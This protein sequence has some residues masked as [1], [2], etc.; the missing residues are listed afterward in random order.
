MAG[1]VLRSIRWTLLGLLLAPIA[2]LLAILPAMSPDRSGI[3]PGAF[4]SG[5]GAPV[6]SVI[7]R[8]A[9]GS[10]RPNIVVILADDLG[11]GDL[12]V[13]G[14]RAIRTPH[15]D[16]LA[17]DG[18]RFT[19]AYSSAPVCSPSRTG[20]L[21]GRYPVR[22]GINTALPAAKDTLVR[23]LLRRS[24][25]ATSHLGIS[26]M[27]GG[28]PV[29]M[30]L[31]P[32]EITIA[33]ALEEAGYR[34]AAFGKWHLGDFTEL[35]EYHPF[36]HGFDEFVGFNVSNDDFPVAFWR[37]DEEIVEDIGADQ[38]HY[39]RLFTEEAIRFIER[40]GG[41]P[42]FVYLCHKDPHL[43][44]FPSEAFAGRS[45]AGPYGDAVEEL[46]W[47]V[48]EIIAALRR[49]DIDRRTLVVLTS[50]NGPWFEGS[51][52][53]LRGRKGQSYEGGFRVP[54]IAWWPGRVSAGRVA[55]V[56]IMNIDLLPT[57]LELAGLEL[58]ADRV[59]DG[60]NLW[61]VLSGG[62]A[63]L[64]QRALFFFHD[65]DAEAVRV[66]DWKYIRANSHYVWPI[67]LDKQDTFVGRTAAGRNYTPPG[68]DE[69]IPTLGTWP[70]LYQ[71]RRDPQEA[72][73]AA[74]KY[75]DIARDLG[76][77]LDAWRTVLRENPRGW[78]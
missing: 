55:D 64:V 44:F 72:Y 19:D 4:E 26:D 10:L 15:M 49:L 36:R 65:Y 31:P 71:L 43:P 67:P 18:M 53:S 78:R 40:A 41:E 35:P 37:G 51:P 66:G 50:D 12:G 42:F 56:P 27:S 13:Q 1:S 77:R 68:S 21:T 76:N 7:R 46:D 11:Y 69:S 14:S 16:R 39:T 22:S 73:N 5:E 30:G 9:G 24:A 63:N 33:E 54:F 59:I 17:A 62:E 47:S 34:T 74:E 8:A 6:S 29:S 57:F 48:G 58:P 3:D 38:R 20:L 52:G 70:L 60:A 75:P 25:V 28:E 61:P 2:L 45:E 23:R 32:S